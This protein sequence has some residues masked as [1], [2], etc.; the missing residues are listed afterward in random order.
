[1]VRR[2]GTFDEALERG[3]KIFGHGAADAAIGELDHVIRAARGDAAAQK[4]LAIDP[5]LAEFVDDERDAAP[6]GVGD[7]M[8]QQARLSGAEEAGDDGDGKSCA[9]YALLPSAEATGFGRREEIEDRVGQKSISRQYSP[10]MW[11][12]TQ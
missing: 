5:Q 7:E 1:M 11:R 3:Q 4:Q 6:C 8:A 2:I 10:P 9:A 12:S